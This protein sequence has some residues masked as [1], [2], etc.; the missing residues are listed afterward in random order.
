MLF[1]SLNNMLCTLIINR[2]SLSEFEHLKV[3]L[4]AEIANEPDQRL[5]QK[6]YVNFYLYHRDVSENAVEAQRWKEAAISVRISK[7]HQTIE[8]VLLLDES[9][10]ENLR[11]LATHNFCVSFITYW[12]FDIP[13]LDF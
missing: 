4:E 7:G 6:T 10:E 11:F 8:N 2:G 1:R 5:K 13:I 9:P 12:H 3:L